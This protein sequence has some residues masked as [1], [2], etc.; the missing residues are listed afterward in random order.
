M[1]D[2]IHNE[3]YEILKDAQQAKPHLKQTECK[4][5]QQGTRRWRFS[6]SLLLLSIFLLILS[7]AL[8]LHNG[9]WAG[10]ACVYFVAGAW[11]LEISNREME[12]TKTDT[13][14]ST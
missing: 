1:S 9:L 2:N 4:F 14:S 12:L 8:P 13:S 3:V 10:M 6:I 11:Q 5:T 7:F